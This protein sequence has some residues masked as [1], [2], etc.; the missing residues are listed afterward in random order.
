[1]KNIK[2]I[3]KSKIWFILSAVL[4]VISLGSL[5]IQGLNFGIDFIGGT[6][7]TI[8]LK[9]PFETSDARTIV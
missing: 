8:D 2:V 9:T 4:I 5:M 6:I 1:M 3:E 7:I